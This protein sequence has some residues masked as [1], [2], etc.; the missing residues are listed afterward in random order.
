M[1][2]MGHNGGIKSQA[3]FQKSIIGH[4]VGVFDPTI[5]GL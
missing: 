2:N 3:V 1:S 5:E 4:S